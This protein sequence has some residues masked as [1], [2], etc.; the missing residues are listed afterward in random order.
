MGAPNPL[1]SNAC[2]PSIRE[3]VFEVTDALGKAAIQRME[4]CVLG[5]YGAVADGRRCRRRIF[6]RFGGRGEDR[7]MQVGVLRLTRLRRTCSVCGNKVQQPRR[8]RFRVT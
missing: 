1:R 6:D 7:G 2:W 8:W 5:Q 3:S 4:V